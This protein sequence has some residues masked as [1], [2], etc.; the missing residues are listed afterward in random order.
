[1]LDVV[2]AVQRWDRRHRATLLEA[3]AGIAGVYV[4][5]FFTPRYH[6][7]GTIAAAEPPRLSGSRCTAMT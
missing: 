1:M 3:L 4:P 7:D 6:D 2:N 5:A